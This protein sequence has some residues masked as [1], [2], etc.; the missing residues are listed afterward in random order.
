MSGPDPEAVLSGGQGVSN[1]PSDVVM[2][3]A[4]DYVEDGADADDGHGKDYAGSGD[5]QGGDYILD[6]GGDGK[7]NENDNISEDDAGEVQESAEND[8]E[9]LTMDKNLDPRQLYVKVIYDLKGIKGTNTA[10]WARKPEEVLHFSRQRTLSELFTLL[11]V[12]VERKFRKGK[13]GRY[14]ELNKAGKEHTIL[15]KPELQHDCPVKQRAFTFDDSGI[16]RVAVI[17][18]LLERRDSFSH[19][20][21]CRCRFHCVQHWH[22]TTASTSADHN[23]DIEASRQAK[24]GGRYLHCHQV[25]RGDNE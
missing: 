11:A 6:G 23:A 17:N 24:Y 7:G 19:R 15:L 4:E 14:K 9:T 3:S 10:M 1:Y 8:P 21:R 5:G 18:D 12:F 2:E 20:C 25:W 22:R 13:P 16:S